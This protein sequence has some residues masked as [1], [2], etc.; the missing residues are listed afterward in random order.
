[1]AFHNK[2]FPVIEDKQIKYGTKDNLRPGIIFC[3]NQSAAIGHARLRSLYEGGD[4]CFP[5]IRL[6]LY[7]E[8]VSKVLRNYK[9]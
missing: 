2:S 1:M 4:S 7:D 8:N 9:I 3:K 6:L 5:T